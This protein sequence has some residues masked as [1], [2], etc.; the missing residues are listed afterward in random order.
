[1]QHSV[2]KDKDVH[3]CEDLNSSTQ[4]DHITLLL[5]ENVDKLVKNLKETKG[6]TGVGVE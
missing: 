5:Q 6:I 2:M 4:T 1:M 3:S